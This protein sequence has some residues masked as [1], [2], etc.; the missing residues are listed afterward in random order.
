[1]NERKFTLFVFGILFGF[2]TGLVSLEAH[3][4]EI[5]HMANA[6][7]NFIEVRGSFDSPDGQYEFLK[8]EMDSHELNQKYEQYLAYRR[9]VECLRDNIFYEAR[10][11]SI[12]GQLAVGFVTINRTRN[13]Y[14]PNTICGVVYE[15]QRDV[16]GNVITNRCQFS[17]TCAKRKPRVNWNN[18]KEHEALAMAEQMA[19]QIINGELDNFIKNVTH[20]HAHYVTPDWSESPRMVHVA[21]YGSHVFYKDVYIARHTI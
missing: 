16:N 19:E 6:V 20:Y 7:S 21:T 3:A 15:G 8:P 12:R 1:M 11:Q 17:W 2:I 18:P 4:S 9:E 10:N 14:Y 13:H 5:R